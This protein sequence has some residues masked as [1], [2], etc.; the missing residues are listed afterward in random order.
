M[1]RVGPLF[2]PAQRLVAELWAR[3]KRSRPRTWR[4][5]AEELARQADQDLGARDALLYYAAG[6]A[7]DRGQHEVADALLVRALEAGPLEPAWTQEAELQLAMAHALLRGDVASARARLERLPSHPTEPAYPLLA[8]ASVLTVEGRHAEAWDTLQRW[9]D[10]SK[11]RGVHWWTGNLWAVELLEQ[12]LKE[13]GALPVRAVGHEI[14]RHG[15][16]LRV[17]LILIGLL[18]AAAFTGM[19]VAGVAAGLRID[20]VDGAS[21]LVLLGLVLLLFAAIGGFG[22]WLVVRGVRGYSRYRRRKTPISEGSAID[23]QR[24][25]A[26]LLPVVFLASGWVSAGGLR[27]FLLLER[28]TSTGTVVWWQLLAIWVA[29]VAHVAVHEAGHALSAVAVGGTLREVAVGK[30]SLQRRKG[31]RLRIRKELPATAGHVQVAFPAP[32]ARLRHAIT[33]AAGPAVTI[34]ASAL[35]ALP[36]AW[37]QW[38][39]PLTRRVLWTGS[40]VGAAVLLSSARR[41]ASDYRLLAEIL[42]GEFWFVDAGSQLGWHLAEGHRAAEWRVSA[43]EIEAAARASREKTGWGLLCAAS[44]ALDLSGDLSAGRRLLEE[45]VADPAADK[46]ALMEAHLQ[47]ALVAALVD[48]D[49]ARARLRIAEAL[50]AGAGEYAA[51]AEAAAALAEGE[52]DRARAALARWHAAVETT[53]LPETA[54]VGNHWAIDRIEAEI[55]EAAPDASRRNPCVLQR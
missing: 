22:A 36:L 42:R 10:A 47:L 11:A 17:G 18:F 24:M 30:L 6:I 49:P 16:P 54:R 5:S 12:R 29:W 43:R 7:R 52:P 31:W 26:L 48:R 3:G 33:V 38:P 28:P 51:I 40:L 20:R 21:P 50:R 4:E 1:L 55:Q 41:S 25:P 15:W 45:L 32:R 35:I 13:A 44:R 23:A 27:A 37:G 46:Q 8:Q 9:K 14:V 2:T 39:D 19:I 53:E 34:C